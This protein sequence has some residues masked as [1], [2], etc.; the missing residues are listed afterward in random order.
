MADRIRDKEIIIG[1]RASKLALI[2]SELVKNALEDKFPEYTFSIKT[3]T[4]KGDT[5]LSKG[6][7]AIGDKGLFTKELELAILNKEIDFAVH[8]L[9]DL[10]A[11]L[12]DGLIIGCVT[13]REDPGDVLIS[14]MKF[15]ELKPG[16]VVGTSALRRKAQLIR[17]RNDLNYKDI[18]GNL[19]TR[20]EK[21]D[22]GLYDAVVVAFAGVKRLGLE[23]R[24]SEIFLYDQMIPAVGQG[25]LAIECNQ[26][27]TEILKIISSLECNITRKIVDTER[28]FLKELRGGCQV[29]LGAYAEIV[30]DKI[31]VSGFVSDLEGE[32]YYYDTLIEA[33]PV[34][35]GTLLAHKLKAMG[36]EGLIDGLIK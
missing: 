35:A 28:A 26:D 2:Q 34:Q 21:L 14:N 33:D 19:N 16:A 23:N 9:K 17:L 29:P 7:S 11:I 4:T 27:D 15:K 10:P 13:E 25:V 5:I 30:D 22:S 36:A 31:R 18:R 24:I 32:K 3:Y 8:S 1:S 12:P 20:L 6:L